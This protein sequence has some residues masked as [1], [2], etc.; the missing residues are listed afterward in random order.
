[1]VV[2][3]GYRLMEQWLAMIRVMVKVAINDIVVVNDSQSSDQ[4]W[5]EW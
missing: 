5:M 1:M 3:S 2:S 4:R